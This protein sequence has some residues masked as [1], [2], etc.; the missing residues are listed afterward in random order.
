M[1][2]RQQGVAPLVGQVHAVEVDGV[3]EI[4]S[5]LP[6]PYLRAQLIAQVAFGPTRH[7]V[8]TRRKLQEHDHC[9]NEQQNQG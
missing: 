9:N 4:G 8:L 2:H 5:K 6:N 7:K 3:A 1:A